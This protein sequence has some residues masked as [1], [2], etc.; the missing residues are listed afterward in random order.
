MKAFSCDNTA[1]V[2]FSLL[3]LI[4]TISLLVPIKHFIHAKD[5]LYPIEPKLLCSTHPFEEPNVKYDM[6]WSIRQFEVM[7][8]S[9]L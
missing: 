5:V 7:T 9:G 3:F 6:K 8:S 2:I 4:H 1:S